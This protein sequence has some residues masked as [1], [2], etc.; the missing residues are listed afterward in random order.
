MANEIRIILDEQEFRQLIKGETITIDSAGTAVKIALA[1]IGYT[2]MAY[3]VLEA[4][5]G[6]EEEQG[7]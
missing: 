4:S 2:Q 3:I 7:T 6:R 1:D 5:L